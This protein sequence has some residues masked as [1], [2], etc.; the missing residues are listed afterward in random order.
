MLGTFDVTGPPAPPHLCPPA[1]RECAP[2]VHAA[3]AA[4]LTGAAAQPGGAE[5]LAE[6]APFWVLN[7]LLLREELPPGLQAAGR[8]VVAAVR[9][10]LLAQSGARLRGF[11]MGGQGGGWRRGQGAV[12]R[13]WLARGWGE[14]AQDA[15]ALSRLC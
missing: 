11:G 14:G 8:Q 7:R 1:C 4:A 5:E 6:L 15:A 12:R 10:A 2:A 3:A 9:D 13:G